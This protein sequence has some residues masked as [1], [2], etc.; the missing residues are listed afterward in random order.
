MKTLNELV[1]ELSEEEVKEAAR[2]I[3]KMY[4]VNVM[5]ANGVFSKFALT[6]LEEGYPQRSHR[7]F[8]ETAIKDRC[9]RIVAKR[10]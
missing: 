10:T 2:E 1:D 4:R 5:K 3:L 8:A 7:V 6:I 9:L